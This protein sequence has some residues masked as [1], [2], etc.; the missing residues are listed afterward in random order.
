MIERYAIPFLH[1]GIPLY[2]SLLN[3]HTPGGDSI[4]FRDFE[5]ETT[6]TAKLIPYTEG[7]GKTLHSSFFIELRRTDKNGISKTF[8]VGTPDLKRNG[9]E[10]Y[11]IKKALVA[12]NRSS[13]IFVIEMRV[14]NGNG[15]DIRYMVETLPF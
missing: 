15:P 2:I 4:D 12:P 1:Q 8:I 9:I 13:M 5:A 10:S 11:S 6:Y 3:G 14:Q 7:Y